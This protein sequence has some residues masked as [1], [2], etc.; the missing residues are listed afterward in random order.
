MSDL[1]HDLPGVICHID[2]ILV[3]GSTRDEHD[4][5]LLAVLERIT[6]AG[7]TL[8]PDKCQFSQPQITFLGHVIDRNGISPDPRKTTAILA[9]KPPSSITELRRFMGINQ[10]S[11]FSPNIAHISKPLRELLSTKSA[12]TWSSAQE[13]SFK[14][15]KEELSS[16]QSASTL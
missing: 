2:D 11:K 10:M 1:L 15:V 12:W 9:M 3:F 13:E 6:T 5:R 4:S 7:I 14:K 16:P 8:N